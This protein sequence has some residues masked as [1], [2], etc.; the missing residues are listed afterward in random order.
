MSSNTRRESQGSVLA[1]AA[2]I[3]SLAMLLAVGLHLLGLISRLNSGLAIGLEHA[4]QSSGLTKTLPSWGLWTATAAVAYGMALAILTVPETWRRVVLWVSLLVLLAGWAPVL[5]LASHVPEV[6][7]PFIAAL[8]SGAC[9]L[10]LAR[11]R[12]TTPGS[13]SVHQQTPAPLP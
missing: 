8:W 10:I 9:A 5:A 7:G 1:T 11:S 6:A 3:G 13:E 4:L 2:V 12:P